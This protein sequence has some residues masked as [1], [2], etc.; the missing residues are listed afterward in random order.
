MYKFFNLNK[1]KILVSKTSYF[2]SIGKRIMGKL[3]NGQENF[4]STIS[5]KI[6][7]ELYLPKLEL[8]VHRTICKYNDLYKLYIQIMSMYSRNF[9]QIDSVECIKMCQTFNGPCFTYGS[10][11]QCSINFSL[12]KT[13]I[14]SKTKFHKCKQ[15]LKCCIYYLFLARFFFFTSMRICNLGTSCKNTYN[16]V[17]NQKLAINNEIFLLIL[18]K[19]KLILNSVKNSWIKV[20]SRQIWNMN[21]YGAEREIRNTFVM[22]PYLNYPNTF[23]IVRDLYWIFWKSMGVECIFP[24]SSFQEEIIQSRFFFFHFFGDVE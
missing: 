6:L 24:L 19:E 9:G 12:T 14:L 17:K 13:E 10:F 5:I 23:V 21:F 16:N 8:S 7:I 4:Q 1:N 11:G 3:S 2:V 18:I 15:I 22:T 20:V